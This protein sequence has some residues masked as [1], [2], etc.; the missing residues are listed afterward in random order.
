MAAPNSGYATG[1]GKDD[2]EL[3]RRNVTGYEKSNGSQVVRVEAE[4]TKKLQKVL[5]Q[6]IESQT[7]LTPLTAKVRLLTG[8]R[9]LRVPHRSSHLHSVCTLHTT[10]EDR[11][12]PHRDLG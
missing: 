8:S 10:M 1:A 7:S 6:T 4:D 3:R 5:C 2:A 9:R 12:F 11:T